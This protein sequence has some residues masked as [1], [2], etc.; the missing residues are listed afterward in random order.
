MEFTEL[1]Y[2]VLCKIVEHTRRSD[3][4]SLAHTCRS[5]HAIVLPL[6]IRDMAITRRWA[7]DTLR[8]FYDY[9]SADE[10]RLGALVSLRIEALPVHK[11]PSSCQRVDPDAGRTLARLIKQL[12][13]L[14]FLSLGPL[15]YAPKIHPEVGDAIAASVT[16]KKVE[17]LHGDRATLTLLLR[18][19]SRVRELVYRGSYHPIPQKELAALVHGVPSISTLS[20]SRCRNAPVA[21][22]RFDCGLRELRLSH[23]HIPFFC[24][25]FNDDKYKHIAA[26]RIGPDVHFSRGEDD[27]LWHFI[28]DGALSS[29]MTSQ[30]TSADASPIVVQAVVLSASYKHHYPCPSS[31][32]NL[33]CTRVGPVK[34]LFYDTVHPGHGDVVKASCRWASEVLCHS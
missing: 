31:G 21:V 17:I 33:A 9:M 26:L 16:L 15:G 30:D 14:R 7:L 22:A 20:L 3:A 10:A 8:Y 6:F 5:M 34:E 12:R 4:L 1:N 24:D 23:C 19:R 32:L 29:H 25:L 13:R 28:V 2:D 11:H 27:A 18:L